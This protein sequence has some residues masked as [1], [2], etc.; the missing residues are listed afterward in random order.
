MKVWTIQPSQVWELLSEKKV[1]YVQP[2]LCEECPLFPEAYS[3]MR[4]KTKDRL[5][6]YQGH[7]PWWGWCY[8]KPDLRFH[9]R[10]GTNGMQ[11]VRIELNI[12][13]TQVLL[14]NESAWIAVL[15][16]IYVSYTDTEGEKWREVLEQHK[17]D[18]RNRPLPEPWQSQLVESWERIFDLDGLRNGGA[19]ADV[20]QATFE[21]LRLANVVSVQP[22]SIRSSV[23]T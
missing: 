9:S 18:D 7:L 15:N 23:A 16:Y 2:D 10:Q 1:L 21:E 14:S 19:W 17:I 4:Q 13:T 6:N 5:P 12:P 22:F 8:P 3:W 20:V 11:L